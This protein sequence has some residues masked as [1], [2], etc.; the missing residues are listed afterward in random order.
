[1]LNN[2]HRQQLAAW[3]AFFAIL[4]AS[5]MPTLSGA[6]ARTVAA[7]HVADI[8]SGDALKVQES[9]QARHH[10]SPAKTGIHLEHCPFC[11]THAGSF[12]LPPT[13]PALLPLASGQ[14]VV[15][16]SWFR[17]RL[18]LVPAWTT[19]PSRAPPLAS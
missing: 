6:F 16:S 12:G 5:V 18:A 2:R 7:P 3:I 13:S 17:S 8:C 19:A 4:A 15:A 14:A 10:S 9:L 11:L 1:M